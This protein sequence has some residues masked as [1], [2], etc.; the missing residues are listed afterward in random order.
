MPHTEV[1]ASTS[2]PIDAKSD[3]ASIPR[4]GTHSTFDSQISRGNK[5]GISCPGGR[6]PGG[7]GGADWVYHVKDALGSE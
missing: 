4:I 7:H 3:L 6:A 5:V 2:V 1:C